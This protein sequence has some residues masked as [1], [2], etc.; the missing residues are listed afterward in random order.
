GTV[1]AALTLNPTSLPATTQNIAYSQTVTA[2]NGTAPY[3]Y[4]LVGS[5][6]TG[7]S[8]NASTG[9]ITGTPTAAGTFNFTI[10]ASDSLGA[11][12][13]RAYSIVINATMS[14]AAAHPPAAHA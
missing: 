12:G 10:N 8:L 1:L 6:P 4:A 5:L 11:F 3:T 2:S 9:A 7:L 13:S 14:L